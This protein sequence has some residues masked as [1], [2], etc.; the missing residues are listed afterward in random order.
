MSQI[1]VLEEIPPQIMEGLSSRIYERIGG[2]IFEVTDQQIVALLRGTLELT[3]NLA[4]GILSSLPSVIHLNLAISNMDF[5]V[6]K[7]R[8]DN[9]ETHLKEVQKK[10]DA[11]DY[12]IDLSTYSKFQSALEQVAVICNMQ[13]VDNRKDRANLA[14]CDLIEARSYYL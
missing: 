2:A 10:L 1:E 6:V 8:L 3:G 5:N 7:E 4:L 12:K 9:I 13:N 11:I 14:I